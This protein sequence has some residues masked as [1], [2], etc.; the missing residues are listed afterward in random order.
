M[1]S[2]NPIFILLAAFLAVYTQAT[3]DTFRNLVGA[4]FDLLPA[5]IVY[6]A[7]THRIEV[8]AALAFCGGIWMDSLSV[9]P[10]GVTVL[11]LFGVGVIIYRYRSLLLRDH[12]YAQ[13]FMGLVASA[14]APAATLII[15][16]SLDTNPIFGWASLW[17]WFVVAII[18]AIATPLC[19]GFFDWLNRALSYQPLPEETFREQRNLHK[20]F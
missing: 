7:L 19:F 10:L 8:V 13:F 18:G 4:Q 9:N 3:F 20:Y 5:L 2:L 17:Q 1:K 16:L 14:I 15:L 12:T 6:T 11:P